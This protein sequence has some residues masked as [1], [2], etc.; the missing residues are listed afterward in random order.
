MSRWRRLIKIGG[1]LIFAFLFAIGIIA[2]VNS[3]CFQQC[4]QA[5]QRQAPHYYFYILPSPLA[6]HIICLGAFF[7]G[8]NAAITALA[9]LVIAIFTYTLWSTSE[10]LGRITRQQMTLT[11]RPRL[12]V[13]NV[14]LLKPLNNAE[15]PEVC[16]ELVNAGSSDA[17]IEIGSVRI[18]VSE[19]PSWRQY[20]KLQI[21][22][23]EIHYID[24]W[25]KRK[26]GEP[27]L[28]VGISD[29]IEKSSDV[30]IPQHFVDRIDTIRHGIPR[31]YIFVVGYLWCRDPQGVH[32]RTGFCR[33]YP[34]ELHRFESVPDPDL[35]Y[36]D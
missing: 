21:P 20:S 28:G 1:G 26:G 29:H 15:P 4:V 17:I 18:V 9:T 32:Y 31:M 12:K 19:A 16:F 36:E 8:H 35:E 30:P 34:S 27:I 3:D 23:G 2:V 6:V 24:N 7:N 11:H 5:H 14:N 33:R 22:D 10:E 13:R 25:M